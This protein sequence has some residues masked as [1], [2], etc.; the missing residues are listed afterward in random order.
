MHRVSMLR[1]PLPD[2]YAP[3][4]LASTLLMIAQDELG[5]RTLAS[6][7]LRELFRRQQPEHP[8]RQIG[9]RPDDEVLD[10]YDVE[11]VASLGKCH[12]CDDPGHYLRECPLAA[13]VRDIDPQERARLT[14]IGKKKLAH[15]PTGNTGNHRF[16]CHVPNK[17]REVTVDN[18]NDEH[19]VLDESAP[20]QDVMFSDAAS[21]DSD[22]DSLDYVAPDFC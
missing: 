22:S 9:S 8:I 6:A 15:R 4:H 17:I 11:A 12:L 13:G 20:L 7:T 5:Q 21:V 16:P 19:T 14:D 1:G 10:Q 3:S 18:P 2:T